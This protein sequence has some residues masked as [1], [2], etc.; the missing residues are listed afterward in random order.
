ML[1]L[2]EKE[3]CPHGDRCQYADSCWG[4]RSERTQVFTCTFIKEDGTIMDGQMRN[5]LDVTGKMK[6]I[7][8]NK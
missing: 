7:M 3:I 4:L 8:E 1:V 2:K 6:I 5:P